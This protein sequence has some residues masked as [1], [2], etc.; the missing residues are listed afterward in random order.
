[1]H[2]KLKLIPKN[3]QGN[4]ISFPKREQKKLLKPLPSTIRYKQFLPPVDFQTLCNC[5]ESFWEY[6]AS[7]TAQENSYYESVITDDHSDTDTIQS[8]SS[9]MSQ[10]DQQ[11]FGEN[12]DQNENDKPVARDFVIGLVA[13]PDQDPDHPRTIQ[14]RNGQQIEEEQ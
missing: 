9:T 3:N 13:H 11:V 2:L 6:A 10:D 5:L 4:V 12:D 1:M 8:E 7:I 14:R